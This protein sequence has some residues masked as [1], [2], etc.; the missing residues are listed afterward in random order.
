[1]Q[2]ANETPGVLDLIFP[3]IHVVVYCQYEQG[4]KRLLA[5]GELEAHVVHEIIR[6]SG[7]Q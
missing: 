2:Y 6:L 4:T 5:I 3:Q 7:W 1:M